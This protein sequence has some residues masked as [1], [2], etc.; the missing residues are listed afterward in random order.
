MVR[1]YNKEDKNDRE[2]L[3]SVVRMEVRNQQEPEFNLPPQPMVNPP[4]P[5]AIQQAP[6]QQEPIQGFPYQSM[7]V[8]NIQIG[9]FPI[10]TIN[11]QQSSMGY[12]SDF[13][14]PQD[15][16]LAGNLGS[17]PLQ[18]ESFQPETPVDNT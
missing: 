7:N 16:E 15:Q 4:M 14:K 10:E 11:R 17:Y 12:P 1:I 18:M 6:I 2:P 9:D 8:N 3:R 5:V 13:A